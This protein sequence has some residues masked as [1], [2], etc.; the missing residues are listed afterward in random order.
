MIA[1]SQLFRRLGMKKKS[2]LATSWHPGGINAIIPVIRRL[3]A[4]GHDVIV[5]GHEFSEPILANSG[6]PFKTIKD[7]GL[8]DVS[9]KS[10]SELLRNP[11]IVPDL[12]LTGTAQQE[13]KADDVLEQ[14]I[15][16]AAR[17]L[18]IKT[19]AVLDFWDGVGNYYKRFTDERTGKK[20][21]L[22]PDRV[23]VLDNIALADM[24]AEGF[25]ADRLEVTGN[26]HFDD[27]PAKAMAFTKEK[28]NEILQKIG[29]SGDTLFFFGGNAFK[30]AN[31]NAGYYWDL[32]IVRIIAQSLQGL[33]NVG[34]A[35]RL[36]PRMPD[37]QKQEIADFIQN[38]G[39][40]M[41]LV[42][43]I[44]SQT[45]ALVADLVIVAF[46][47]LGLE[48]VFMRRPCVSAQ[49]GSVKENDVLI[50]SNKGVIPVGYTA[51]DCRQLLIK[52]ADPE[53][54]RQLLEMSSGFATDGKA[55]E[56]VVQLVY[57]LLKL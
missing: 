8:S 57:S 55:T 54:R 31:S 36:H 5:L 43:D 37:D 17:R 25:P 42:T 39:A 3:K 47:T 44:D 51:Q 56:R 16:V 12:V 7:F 35:V 11:Q 32:D 40:N 14:T 19:L 30:N 46:S 34:T 18:G 13:G 23:G 6:L 26:P 9:L 49:P 10:M 48:A 50:V 27:L 33:G 22:L 29:L 1:L 2:I 21:E 28:R 52:A 20:L 53:Y 15:A 24:L 38:S 4:D 45:L 41:K